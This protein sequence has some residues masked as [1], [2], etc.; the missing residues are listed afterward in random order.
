MSDR[1]LADD[2]LLTARLSLQRPAEAD[3]DAIF[4]IH[5]DPATCLHNSSDALARRDEAGEP[6]RGIS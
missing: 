1:S 5:S 3:I 4:A 6:S 2:E